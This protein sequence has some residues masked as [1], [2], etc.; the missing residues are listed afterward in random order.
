M[1]EAIEKGVSEIWGESK[2]WKTLDWEV[3]TTAIISRAASSIF[4]GPELASD[5][6]WQTVSPKYVVDFFS[7]VPEMQSVHPWL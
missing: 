7:A 2:E 6:E 5:P 4:V 1:N 3:D